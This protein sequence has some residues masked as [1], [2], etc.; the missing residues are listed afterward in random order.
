VR[1]VA[2]RLKSGARQEMTRIVGLDPDA[3]LHR[4]LGPEDRL[5]APIGRGLVLD[6]ALAARLAL[7]PGDR[8]W[9]EVLDGRGGQALL[10]IT[11]LA[12][13]YS[14]ATAYMDRRALNRLMGE[15]DIASGAELLVA[16]DAR[17][18]FYRE[19][20]AAPQIV[21][22]SS[23]DDTVAAW[24]AVMA[25]SFSTAILFYLGFAGAIAFGV[26][27]NMCRISLAERARDLATLRV[28]GFAP[29]TCAYV[30]LGE[31]AVLALSAV[32]IGVLGGYGLSHGLVAAYSREDVRFP[33][34]IAADSYGVA[35]GAYLMIVALAGGLAARRIWGFDL[36]AV[37]KTRE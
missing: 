37:L 34:I 24:R 25:R 15:G 20:E 13:D 29:A 21:G 1:V 5:A 11:G 4:A 23:R 16:A 26:A 2:V 19:I 32:P 9:V 8:V 10:P 17:R 22:A 31:L 6:E 12:R 36:V 30:L 7:K 14:G 35:I 3:M 33:A 18:A 27:Y 28:L